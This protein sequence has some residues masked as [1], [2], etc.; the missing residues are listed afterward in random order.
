MHIYAKMGA[1]KYS[2]L[3][4][5]HNHTFRD[6]GMNGWMD[7]DTS[8]QHNSFNSVRI[9][10]QVDLYSKSRSDLNMVIKSIFDG[11]SNIYPF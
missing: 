5:V 11:N 4:A 2:H 1:S 3:F 10:Q 8:Y 9:V 7:A 6:R